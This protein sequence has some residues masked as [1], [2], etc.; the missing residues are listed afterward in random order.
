V[1]LDWMMPGID[2]VET[3][4]RIRSEKSASILP[5]IMVTAKTESENI[6]EAIRLGANDY[7]TK[8]V[9]FAVALARVD[10]HI[11]RKRAEAQARAAAGA[12]RDANDNL[13]RN[14]A[15][16][17]TLLLGLYQKLKAEMAVR[18]KAD[19]RSQH[20][21]YHDSLTGLGNRLM[22]KEQ[23]ESAL[24]DVWESP[25]PVAVLFMDL[26]G[27]KGVNDTL[28]H[29]VGDL[30]L[31][32][33]AVRVRD[34]LP[35]NSH[36]ARFGG[37]E[38]AILQTSAEQP[39]A[40]ITLA[41]H[42]VDVVGQP[43]TIEGYEVNVSVSIGIVVENA[44]HMSAENFLKSADIAM[45]GAKA[46]GPGNYRMFDAELEA[47]VQARSALE[48]EMRNGIM[49][50]QFKAYYQPLLNLQ[51]KKVTAFEALIR[52]EHPERGLVSPAEF[53]PVAEETGLIVRLGEWMM[54]EACCEA[55]CWPAEISVSINLSAVQF[56]KGDLVATVVKA[57]GSSGL[58]ASR[59][60]LEVTESVLLEKADENVRILNQLRELGVRIAMDDFGTG[61]SSI[62][63]LRSFK[64]DK[65]KI[66]RSFVKE[67]GT[68]EESLAIVRAIVGLGSSFGIIT[69]AEGVETEAQMNR[70]NLEG[71][72]EV[73]GFLYSKPLPPD[74]IKKLLGRLSLAEP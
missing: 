73:Q 19:A 34:I 1:L 32:S 8:P 46:E 38:F 22:F 10:A 14:V 60:E 29:S 18:E 12:L 67:L 3:L 47:V 11:G 48:R 39:T 27:F 52:W 63:Y 16:R 54:R 64:F 6:V 25:N 24:K 35:E 66:D 15:E 69:T 31:K 37:D 57:L 51:T 56:A 74:Q 61:Y 4:R 53:I 40:A 72:T 58:P 68:D 45:Y 30:L 71:C 50:N 62:A 36:L 9:D 42:I 17:T 20:L 13:E 26:D 33:I 44:G 5:V 41:Q 65:L 43:V 55:M 49:Q 2:G 70:L 59:L 7:V 21:A 28:G 23:L